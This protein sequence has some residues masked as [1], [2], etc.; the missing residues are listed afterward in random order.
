VPFFIAL[1]GLKPRHYDR[2]LDWFVSTSLERL[3]GLG[4]ILHLA[5]ELEIL[6]A[7]LLH[8]RWRCERESRPW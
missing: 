7:R 1:A 3:F 6:V 2:S 5:I 8:R 4:E